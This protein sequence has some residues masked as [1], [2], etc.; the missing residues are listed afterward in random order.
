MIKFAI[1]RNTEDEYR[2]LLDIHSWLI[3]HFD[4]QSQTTWQYMPY[5]DQIVELVFMMNQLQPGLD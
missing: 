2:N 5:T 4:D 3:E 1:M